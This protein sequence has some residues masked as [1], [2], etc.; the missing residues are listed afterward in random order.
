[1]WD[2]ILQSHS[3]AQTHIQES[4]Y[5]WVISGS[6]SLCGSLEPS[7]KAG[8]F[9]FDTAFRAKSLTRAPH[10]QQLNPTMISLTLKE[11]TSGQ[12]PL[13]EDQNP[14]IVS[15]YTQAKIQTIQRDF[16]KHLFSSAVWF[17]EAELG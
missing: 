7:R 12:N 15:N 13:T 6:V 10:C 4:I 14:L 2:R 9:H 1:M 17:P 16:F 11:M 3:G 5:K 8:P